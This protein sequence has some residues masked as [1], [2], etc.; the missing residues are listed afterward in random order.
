MSVHVAKNPDCAAR[1]DADARPKS[2]FTLPPPDRASGQDIP[3]S[4]L[5]YR[6]IELM[7]WMPPPNGICY[8]MMVLS[9]PNG[10]QIDDDTDQHAGDCPGE[11]QLRGLRGR[12]GRL[13]HS[14]HWCRF[15]QSHGVV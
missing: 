14:H 5:R 15:A 11:G 7:R 2:R 6:Q 12:A 8:A 13:C 9:E 4:H 10:G 1:A 3:H